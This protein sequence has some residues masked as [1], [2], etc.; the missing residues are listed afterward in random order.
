MN[1]VMQI[2]ENNNAIC[3]FN[4]VRLYLQVTWLSE[5]SNALG[6]MILPEMLDPS[7][8]TKYPLKSMLRWPVQEISPR[9]SWTQWKYLLRK[10][11]LVSKNRRLGNTLIEITLGD[12]FPI[13]DN[14]QRWQWEQTIV[15]TMFNFGNK[16][17]QYKITGARAGQNH[18]TIN[19]NEPE[20][21]NND[22]VKY[23]YPVDTAQQT[24]T[25]RTFLKP[26][27]KGIYDLR[28]AT[29][30]TNRGDTDKTL[31]VAATNRVGN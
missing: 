17:Q 22:E 15:E 13:P 19:T 2:K 11:L 27:T 8:R 10:R 14:H 6:T 20:F 7:D 23:G 4:Q 30:T 28:R 31:N 21:I 29:P 9:K 25:T 18:V 3:R 5:I 16:Q 26:S 12:F 1:T 24:A